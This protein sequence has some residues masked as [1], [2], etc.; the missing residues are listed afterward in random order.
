MLSFYYRYARLTI[1]L[2]RPGFCSNNH[3]SLQ[4]LSSPYQPADYEQHS[5]YSCYKVPVAQVAIATLA[6]QCFSHCIF[7]LVHNRRCMY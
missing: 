4:K 7:L 2:R 1:E 5:V 3:K 6:I